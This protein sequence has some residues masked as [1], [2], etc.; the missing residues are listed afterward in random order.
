M[1]TPV[2][3]PARDGLRRQVEMHAT[4]LRAD[5]III[6]TAIAGSGLQCLNALALSA[7]LCFQFSFLAVCRL[8]WGGF[9]PPFMR[10]HRLKNLQHTPACTAHYKPTDGHN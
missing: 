3:A 10:C 9:S 6:L 2:H 1:T 5:C 8:P 7:C 4:S